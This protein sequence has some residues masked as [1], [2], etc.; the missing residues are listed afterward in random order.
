MSVTQAPGYAL[1]HWNLSLALLSHGDFEA[2]WREYEWR[3]HWPEFPEVRRKLPVRTWRG[4]DLTGKRILVWAEQGYGN[5]IQF[6]PLARR[7]LPLAGE[8]LLEVPTPLVRLFT[9]SFPD[10]TVVCRPD[11][12]HALLADPLP[13]YTIPLM[14]LSPSNGSTSS[15]PLI[16]GLPI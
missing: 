4:E 11:V 12:P 1:G 15:L 8:V 2:G 9:A 13:D 3:W 14:S 7:L 5:A 10:L 16:P 6:A